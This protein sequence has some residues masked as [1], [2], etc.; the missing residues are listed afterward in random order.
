MLE[1]ACRIRNWRQFSI[2]T[3][4]THFVNIRAS[5]AVYHYAQP[6]RDPLNDFLL[7]LLRETPFAD[8]LA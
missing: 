6:I 7:F 3:A 1:H 4:A 8:L 2:F 5:A